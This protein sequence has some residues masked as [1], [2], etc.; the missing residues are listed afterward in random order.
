METTTISDNI[1]QFHDGLVKHDFK[2]TVCSSVVETL[3]A[4]PDNAVK[5]RNKKQVLLL[6]SYQH[7]LLFLC[8]PISNEILTINSAIQLLLINISKQL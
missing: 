1:I 5:Y 2:G 3:Y 8:T 7:I 4:L 6:R